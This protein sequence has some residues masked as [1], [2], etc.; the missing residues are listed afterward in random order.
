[1]KSQ[2]ER[3][4]VQD[5][6]IIRLPIRLFEIFAG[7]KNGS[8]TVCNARIQG[9]Y[10]LVS[11][12]FT[13]FSIDP[14]SKNDQ[15]VVMDIDVQPGDLVLRDRGY[16]SIASID[17]FKRAGADTIMRYKSKTHVFDA[18]TGKEI[19]LVQYLTK[20]QTMDQE[21]LLGKTEKL[22]V[23]LVAHPVDEAVANMRRRKLKTEYKGRNPSEQLL[24]IQG[25][26]L[27]ITSITDPE[28]TF[29]IIKY[30]YRLRWRIEIIFK[31]WK[32]HM[33]FTKIHNVSPCQI[34]VLI[35]SRLLMATL[36]IHTIFNPLAEIIMTKTGRTLSMMK[37]TR[38][39]TNNLD[40]IRRFTYETVSNQSLDALIRYCCYDKRRRLNFEDHITEAIHQANMYP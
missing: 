39:I 24:K 16:F 19:N 2:F 31:T 28:I 11:R 26:T 38:Y 1:M 27:F 12:Q 21:I 34:Q 10:D 9:T 22:R 15:S 17:V 25:W 23:R 8:T 36:L 5:S 32:S 14:Y 7:V 37:F 20:N 6:T 29:D 13:A 3:I 35:R 33:N 40:D 18:Q 30:L 4:L